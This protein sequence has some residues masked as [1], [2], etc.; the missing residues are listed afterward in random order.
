MLGSTTAFIVMP[1]YNPNINTT[2]AIDCFNLA[3]VFMVI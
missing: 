1:I 2:N 3:W